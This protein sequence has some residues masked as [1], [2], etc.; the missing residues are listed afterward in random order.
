MLELLNQLFKDVPHLLHGGTGYVVLIIFGISIIIALYR[1]SKAR[2]LWFTDRPAYYEYK[3]SL[4]D[5]QR[6]LHMQRERQHMIEQ[7]QFMRQEELSHQMG[8]SS[9]YNYNSYN[10]F[11]RSDPNNPA[12]PDYWKMH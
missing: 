1:S 11:D 8:D 9:N 7:E 5:Q 10:P 12:N 4:R 6:N 3:Q 2:F